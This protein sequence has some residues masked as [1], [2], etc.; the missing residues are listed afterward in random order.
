VGLTSSHLAYVI[1]TSGS[2]G[3]PK[4]VVVPHRAVLRLVCGTDC[5]QLGPEDTVA[6]IANPAFDASTFEFW[7]ALLNGARIVPIAKTTAITRTGQIQRAFPSSQSARG[8]RAGRADSGT[9][10]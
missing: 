1:Y 5:A 2:T 9:G 4:G 6:Q 8:C 3:A 7:G 10:S